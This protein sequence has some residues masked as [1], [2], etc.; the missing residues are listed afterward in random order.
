MAVP[1]LGAAKAVIVELRRGNLQPDVEVDED[2]IEAGTP[3]EA[4]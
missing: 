4:S 1:L 3:S 2:D